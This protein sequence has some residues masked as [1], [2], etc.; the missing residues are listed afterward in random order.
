MPVP[1]M[2]LKNSRIS[3]PVSCGKKAKIKRRMMTMLVKIGPEKR[4]MD[5]KYCQVPL[6]AFSRVSDG[7]G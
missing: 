1:L 7:C 3:S 6:G 2:V 4:M 5:Q